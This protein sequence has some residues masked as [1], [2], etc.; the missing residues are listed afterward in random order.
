MLRSA[1]QRAHLTQQQLA[2]RAG[3]TQSVV[4]AY[5]SGRRQPSVPT[6]AALIAATGFELDL[7]L[8]TTPRRLDVLTGPIGRRVRRHRRQLLDTATAHGIHGLRVFG[9]VARGED[10]PGSDLDL[11]ADLPPGMGL[12]G[13]GRARD[14]LGAIIGCSVD[15]VPVTDLKAGVREHV[16]AEMVAL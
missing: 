4:S 9:S 14:A 8:R 15:L 1:R 16:E 12:I 3:V 7:Q 5:E 13:L 6:L 11:L 10:Q 2:A